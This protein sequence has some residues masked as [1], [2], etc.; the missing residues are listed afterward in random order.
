MCAVVCTESEQ[1]YQSKTWNETFQVEQDHTAGAL[2]TSSLQYESHGTSISPMRR[3]HTHLGV[4]RK[5]G[6]AAKLSTIVNCQ[7]LKEF[8]TSHGNYSTNTGHPRLHVQPKQCFA[9][10]T[11]FSHIAESCIRETWARTRCVTPPTS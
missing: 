11:R 3:C 8:R 1:S 5:A 7:R 9:R 6:T 4:S 2:D 10:S